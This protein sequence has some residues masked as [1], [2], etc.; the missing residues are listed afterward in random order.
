MATLLGQ[1]QD[2]R[3]RW[4]ELRSAGKCLICSAGALT[5]A[6]VLI[7]SYLNLN[8]MASLPMPDE[9]LGSTAHFFA[10][11]ARLDAVLAAA[12]ASVL[13]ICVPTLFLEFIRR[14]RAA[15]DELDTP[16]VA[17]S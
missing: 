13:T 8:F 10:E 17:R 3:S 9:V 14:R 5:S 15:K 2:P 16:T 11:R 4:R 12:S 7:N 6:L 1:N